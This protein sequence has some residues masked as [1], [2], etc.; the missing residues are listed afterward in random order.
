[1]KLMVAD[2]VPIGESS[3]S[4]FLAGSTLMLSGKNLGYWSSMA[5]HFAA[6]GFVVLLPASLLEL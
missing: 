4:Q 5:Y 3:S 6:V 1:M 2:V